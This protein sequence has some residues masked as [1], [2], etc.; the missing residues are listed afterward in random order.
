MKR[1]LVFALLLGLTFGFVS[2][3]Y[4]QGEDSILAPLL[5]QLLVPGVLGAAVGYVF[6]YIVEW[7]PSF[8]QQSPLNKRL[9]FFLVCILV[10]TAA[11]AAISALNGSFNW[12][13]ILGNALTTSLAAVSMGTLAHS[14]NLSR[15][16]PTQF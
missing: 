5:G 6:S 10:S 4:A 9:Y 11:G 12:D 14:R 3:A 15:V 13:H 7:F 2:A 8:M 16:Q 1:W